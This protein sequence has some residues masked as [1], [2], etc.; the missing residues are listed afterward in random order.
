M[1]LNET[2]SPAIFFGVKKSLI[3]DFVTLIGFPNL[4]SD[5]GLVHQTNHEQQPEFRF[6]TLLEH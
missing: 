3:A 4:I 2:L 1:S 6:L 5:G